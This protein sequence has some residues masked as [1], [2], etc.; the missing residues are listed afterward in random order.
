MNN[1]KYTLFLF[2]AMLQFSFTSDSDSDFQYRNQT[3]DAFTF[4]EELKF[5]I[6]YG[7]INAGYATI[8]IDQEPVLIK[9]RPTYHI[10]AK[11]RTSSGFDWMYRVRDHFE[12]WVDVESM[13]PLK[14]FKTVKENKYR[15]T[16]LVY[17]N[18]EKESIRGKKKNM[19]MPRYA[20]DIVSSVFYAR[21]LDFSEAKK[22][23]AFP[24]NV[25]LD[26]EIY[27]LKFKFLG[28]ETLSTK[29]GK[30]KCIKIRPQVVADRIFKD[31]ESLS[32]WVSDDKNR[33]PIRVSS[34]LWVGSVRFDLTSHKGLK[35]PFGK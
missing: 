28:R 34:A 30:I 14:Y 11:G 9:G 22:G 17:Y 7:F 13:A 16:D 35:H 19:D 23:D 5:K 26:Q 32:I 8:K 4:G 20:Q 27:K 15:D 33:I 25:Y 12:S 1:L 31:E 10:T 3:N 29:F 18:H 21:T 24:I 6:H 2:A